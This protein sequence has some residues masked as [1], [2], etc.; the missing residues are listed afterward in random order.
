MV[1]QLF[2]KNTRNK[3]NIIVVVDDD[4]DVIFYINI[5]MSFERYTAV[6]AKASKRKTRNRINF[7]SLAQAASKLCVSL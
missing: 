7:V 4:D 5:K 3:N 6:T 2:I 1:Q